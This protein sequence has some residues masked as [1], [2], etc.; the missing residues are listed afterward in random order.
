MQLEHTQP[1]N[2]VLC[3]VMES[4]A[5]IFV[6]P[7]SNE[8]IDWDND[9]AEKYIH[10]QMQ[11]DGPHKGTLHLY[12]PQIMMQSIL[13]NMLGEDEIDQDSSNKQIDALGELLNVICGQI[14]TE[15]WG[16]DPIFDLRLPHVN[17][18]EQENI[19]QMKSEPSVILF[20]SDDGAVFLHLDIEDNL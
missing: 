1:A 12:V 14:L 5:F 8:Q 7:V 19:R 2:N 3:S 4:L 15:I 10:A 16:T 18:I 13:E 9:L 17:P 20:S 11:F 6:D